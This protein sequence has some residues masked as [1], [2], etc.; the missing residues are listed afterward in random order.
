METGLSERVRE[1]AIR[2]YVEPARKNGG[3]IAIRIGEIQNKLLKE[4]FPS[5]HMRQIYTSLESKRLFLEPLGLILET[6]SGQPVRVGTVLRFAISD[7]RSSAAKRS[8]VHGR[9]LAP[10]GTH[11]SDQRESLVNGDGA[12]ET[13]EEWARRVTDK[14]AGLL[15]EEIASFGGVDAFMKWVRSDHDE[16]EA[17]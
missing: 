7:H 2:E 3:K 10:G 13:S 1:L 11:S 9:P 5:N 16:E 15:K 8:G 12:E 4:G 14:L 17:E 6:P